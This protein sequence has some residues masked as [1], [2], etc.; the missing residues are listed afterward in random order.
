MEYSL[1]LEHPL[2]M[3]MLEM[4][5][6]YCHDEDGDEDEVWKVGPGPDAGQS[7][8]RI[9]VAQGQAVVSPKD[10]DGWKQFENC[11]FSRGYIF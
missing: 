10:T 4:M 11:H 2:S 9:V 3:T 1:A 7:I 5:T 8:F 6:E